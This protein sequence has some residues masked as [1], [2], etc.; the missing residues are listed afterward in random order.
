MTRKSYL[1]G[2]LLPFGICTLLSCGGSNNPTSPA[3]L[4]T[5][6]LYIV[7]NG[8]VTTY[9]IDPVSLLA[10]PAEQA[11][12]LTSPDASLLQFDPSPHDNFLYAVWSDAHSVQHLSV[13]E[14]D[15]SGVPQLPAT[16]TLDADAL[17]QFNMHPG[18]R[19]AY[20]LQV[21]SSNNQY[22][23]KIRLFK[24][25]AANG[26]LNGK[27]NEATSFQGAYGPAPFW[28]AI[29]Y[30]FSPDARKLYIYSRGTTGSAYL[31]R[32]INPND[33]TLGV[34]NQL[35]TLNGN[36]D[37]AIG[38]VIAVLHPNS[39]TPNEGYVD[40]FPNNPN[41]KRAIHCTTAM[42]TFCGSTSYIKLDRSGKYLFLTDPA[43]GAIHIT[44]INTT[45]HKIIDTGNSLPMTSQIPGFVFNHDGSIL[46]VM[47]TDGNLHLFH[48]DSSSGSL[49]E[50]GTPLPLAQGSGICPAHHS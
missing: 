33:G 30:G 8:S 32:A 10:T 15:A 11:V 1:L 6:I 26:Q 19:F 48:F 42:L 49:T 21:T 44:Q 28:P 38:A 41:P 16:Q 43:S 22:S 18:G 31:Q 27:L 29:L 3:K 20:M 7:Q 39:V 50:G 12:T 45:T 5:E 34:S 9:S 47:E 4:S 40:I 14:T 25:E 35:I 13:Y 24:V 46:Y 37:V 17:S 23:A 36:Q 2:F